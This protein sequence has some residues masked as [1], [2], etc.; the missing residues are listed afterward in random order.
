[1]D[2]ERPEGTARNVRISALG[3]TELEN[4]NE[5]LYILFV[6]ETKKTPTQ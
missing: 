4:E 1:M 6:R 3:P 2:G 5:L